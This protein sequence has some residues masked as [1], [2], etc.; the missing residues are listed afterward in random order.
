MR[1]QVRPENSSSRSA[2]LRRFG[3]DGA[4]SVLTRC[5]AVLGHSSVQTCTGHTS[6]PKTV[7]K[8]R[9]FVE[10]SCVFLARNIIQMLFY[11]QLITLYEVSRLNAI[12]GCTDGLVFPAGS[13]FSCQRAVIN[14]QNSR[15]SLNGKQR[16]SGMNRALSMLQKYKLNLC[17]QVCSF[18]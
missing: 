13:C 14:L 12:P 16:C 11:V 7:N 3:L 9:S 17:L 5:L 4:L 6:K 1:L 10:F 18:L 15:T 2:F 8:N